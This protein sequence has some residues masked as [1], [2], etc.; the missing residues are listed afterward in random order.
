MVDGGWQL[1]TAALFVI[2]GT[3]SCT[4]CFRRTSRVSG[5]SRD[6]TSGLPV[7]RELAWRLLFSEFDVQLFGLKIHC[8][9]FDSKRCWTNHAVEIA[10]RLLR[11]GS[12]KDAVNP[13]GISAQ[14][15]SLDM[16]RDQF[17]RACGVGAPSWR[18]DRQP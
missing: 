9:P 10:K 12:H 11:H 3:G 16:E 5:S 17:S 15:Q 6:P 7:I 4:H 8:K 13:H 14:A 18:F 2:G 1:V